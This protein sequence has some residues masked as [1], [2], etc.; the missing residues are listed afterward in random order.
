MSPSHVVP[1]SAG[2]AIEPTPKLNFPATE[3]VECTVV[4]YPL[5]ESPGFNTKPLFGVKELDISFSD[6][7]NPPISPLVAVILPPKS[8]LLAVTFPSWSTLNALELIK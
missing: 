1:P 4:P 2:G 3:V 6:I 7:K 8:I 5:I